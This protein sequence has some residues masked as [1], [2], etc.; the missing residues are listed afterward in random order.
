M[1]FD[2]LRA[3]HLEALNIAHVL[4]GPVVLLDLP[5]PVMLFG[6]GTAAKI[7]E[8]GFIDQEGGIMA[9]LVF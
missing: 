9:R 2:R 3:A 6:E 1:V 4:D 7:G 8:R 5:M